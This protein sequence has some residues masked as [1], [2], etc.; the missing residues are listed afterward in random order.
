MLFVVL[1]SLFLSPC[2]GYNIDD[3]KSSIVTGPESFGVSVAAVESRVFVGAHKGTGA[4]FSCNLT[5]D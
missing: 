1:A 3:A 2:L 5:G 4:V